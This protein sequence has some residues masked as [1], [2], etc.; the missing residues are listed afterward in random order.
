MLPRPLS[1]TRRHFVFDDLKCIVMLSFKNISSRLHSFRSRTVPK[2][3]SQFLPRR[4]RPPARVRHLQSAV[5]CERCQLDSG[6]EEIRAVGCHARYDRKQMR[7]HVAEKSR[8]VVNRISGKIKYH[9]R[10]T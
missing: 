10:Y 5:V 2:R 8:L 4:L 7:L 6:R 3:D 9:L 1:Q